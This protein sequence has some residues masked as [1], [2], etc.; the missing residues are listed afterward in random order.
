[1]LRNRFVFSSY[2]FVDDKKIKIKSLINSPY[3][4]DEDK[5]KMLILNDR[6]GISLSACPYHVPGDSHQ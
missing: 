1:M 2:S 4:I 5:T 6:T 3:I